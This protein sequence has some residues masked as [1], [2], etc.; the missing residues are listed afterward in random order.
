M[1]KPIEVII[2]KRL[3]GLHNQVIFCYVLNN[4]SLNFYDSNKRL[5]MISSPLLSKIYFY[6]NIKNSCCTRSEISKTRSS[7]KAQNYLE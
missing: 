4:L 7:I 6:F 3:F 2:E 5:V 1:P